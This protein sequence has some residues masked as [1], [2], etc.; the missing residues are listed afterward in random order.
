MAKKKKDDAA[1]D[2][3]GDDEMDWFDDEDDDVDESEEKSP[4]EPKETLPVAPPP[5]PPFKPAG[6]DEGTVSPLQSEDWSNRV[7]DAPADAKALSSAP[8]LVFSS[9]P[10]LPPM[11]APDDSE[12]AKAVDVD[13]TEDEP[14]AVEPRPPTEEAATEE[15]SA[16]EVAAAI[17]AA[18]PPSDAE[19]EVV[20]P[21]PEPAAV[22]EPQVVESGDDD[23]DEAEDADSVEEVYGD[24]LD[25]QTAQATP[26]VHSHDPAPLR[27]DPPPVRVG[28]AVQPAASPEPAFTPPSARPALERWTPPGDD[29]AWREVAM[30][31]VSEAAAAKGDARAHLLF[32]AAT[33][34]YTR[35]GD[36]DGAETLFRD[37]S[38]AG[39]NDLRL[40]RALTDIAMAADR[41]E[42]GLK[43]LSDAAAAQDG[44]AAAELFLEA[45]GVAMGHLGR[46]DDAAGLARQAV[47]AAPN[48]YAALSMLRDLSSQ[49]GDDAEKADVLRRLAE[50]SEGYVAADALLELGRALKQN[51]AEGSLQALRDAVKASPIHGSAWL[52]LERS[53]TER[54]AYGELAALYTT[55][56]QR[57]GQPDAG[58]WSLR[59]ARAHRDGGASE[60]AEIAFGHAVAAGYLFAEREL[61]AAHI[62]D[63]A[64]EALA[65]SLEAEAAAIE[66]ADAAFTWYRLALVREKHLDNASGALEAYKMVVRLD[67]N[68]TPAGDAAGRL[69]KAL[70]QTDD[71]MGFWQSRLDVATDDANRAAMMFRMAEIAEGEGDLAKAR[72]WYEQALDTGVP[73]IMA[74]TE[75]G[76]ARVL[77]ALGAWTELAQLYRNRASTTD[78]PVAKAEALFRAA[79]VG[80]HEPTDAELAVTD[81]RGVLAVSPA[82][83]GALGLVDVLLSAT[84]LWADLAEILK[85]AAGAT[86][87]SSA[88]A[89]LL[90]RAGRLFADSVSDSSRAQPCLE[91]SV[92]ADPTFLPAVW[93]LRQIAGAASENAQRELYVKQSEASEDADIA[94][95]CLFAASQLAGAAES[96]IHLQKLLDGR[97]DHPG[98]LAAMEIVCLVGGESAALAE[99]YAGSLVGPP[100]AAGARLTARIAELRAGTGQNDEALKALSDLI[101]MES[102]G[103]PLRGAARLAEGLGAWNEAAA[104]LE[105]LDNYED[106][107]HRSRILVRKLRNPGA[108]LPILKECLESPSSDLG[109]ALVASVVARLAQ[110]RDAMIRAHA[111]LATMAESPTLK[112]AYARWT[113]GMLAADNREDEALAYWQM[114]LALRPQSVVAFEGVERGMISIGNGDGLKQLYA[115]QRPSDLRGLAMALERAEEDEPAIEVLRTALEGD[116]PKLANL[117]ILEQALTRGEKWQEVYD[118]V[119]RRREIVVDEGLKAQIDAKRRW[120]L[121]EKL[122]ET[123]TA[124]E[125][126]QKLHEES[127]DDREVTEA[128]ARI[129]GARG[130]TDRAIQYLKELAET[131]SDKA[132][133][134]RYQRRVG[135]AYES[136]GDTASARQAYLDALDHV[137][138]DRAALDGLKRLAEGEEDWAGMV[139]VLQ[140]EAGI[141]DDDRRLELRREIAMITEDKIG[142]PAVAM[143]AWRAVLEEAQHD[144]EALEHLLGLS[145]SQGEWGVFIETG[146][147]LAAITAGPEQA[148]LFRRMGIVCQEQLD[149]DDAIRY[150][151][152]AVA[153][154]APDHEAAVQL[155]GMYRSR[156]DWSGAV[157]TLQIQ[158]KV[159]E[160]E[161]DRVAA[162]LK[163]AQ[164]EV[165]NRHDRDAAS[166]FFAQILDVDPKQI[167]AMR[168]MSNHLFETEKFEEALA[169]CK[170]L[171]PDV[172]TDQDMEDFDTRMEVSSF[173]FCFGEML[174]NTEQLDEALP[175]YER[176]L[177]LN[178][179]H[180][181][182]LEAIGPL[183][184]RD[185]QWKKAERVYRQLLQL[186]G[187]QG[188]RHAVAS[189]YTQLGLVERKLGSQDKAYKR[190]NK[191]LEMYP[192]HVGA[193]NGMALIL[194]DREDWSNLLN[195]YNNIIYH[196]TAHNDVIDAYM[197]KGRIL[198]DHMTRPD[199]AAQHYQRSLDFDSRQPVAYVRLAELAMRRDDYQEA[200][201]LAEAALALEDLNDLLDPVRP[202]LLL[203]KAAALKDGGK[204]DAAAKS[205]EEARGKAEKELDEALGSSPLDDL[206]TLRQ[207]IKDAI[208][209]PVR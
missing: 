88:K 150:L 187:G 135:D 107:L 131:A 142:D 179:T 182:T 152:Q 81:L 138:D 185:E 140:R 19:T 191:A 197:T 51:D 31:M 102:E 96:R 104:L 124:W 47:S 166:T 72:E 163:A 13:Q 79:T 112:G 161:A 170:R 6:A 158:G 89:S 82:H 206:D 127:P 33:I 181:A 22:E 132:E 61:Q 36:H 97:P 59:A 201:T 205:L 90:Y 129:A 177:E 149:R 17:E 136:N 162:L 43:H 195:I 101:A 137:P 54:G 175:R 68:A 128:V 192:N 117:L 186:S 85:E 62:K 176:A 119:A 86:E 26:L 100:T 83:S 23:A 109:A 70:G 64:W 49:I 78:S 156:A 35:V 203:C 159:A 180:L 144:T 73:A 57:E 48:D 169:V 165:G 208:P 7:S 141:A 160:A 18:G 66:G 84:E 202:L 75:D 16:D 94:H 38:S 123:D 63:S 115:E 113:A 164:I 14:T 58:W 133:S 204:A 190:F 42:D 154:D 3:F 126:Y 188:E 92:D 77:Y 148:V 108:S 45:A 27:R 71:L 171:E 12:L 98:A 153:G 167:D 30:A 10:T 145:E 118:V 56:A 155:E 2:F 194:E 40:R 37:A 196:A 111:A 28:V 95:W 99:L 146:N 134:A 80:K 173:F 116:G 69:M 55:E 207:V 34:Y 189:T 106:K 65:K 93:L 15:A 24:D 41:F 4:A 157:R 74:P 184:T 5:P 105:S 200:G 39:L 110:D 53:L 20:E 87:D 21:E 174:N 168:F 52:E 76:L 178:P 114:D 125:L 198:D 151:E 139:Q 143:D 147:S 1:A 46:A 121:A 44:D 183:Y 11:D 25:D 8:T 193:L 199:K 172:E 91:S 103:R 9:V 120:L 209:M 29:A 60:E 67:G 122:A 32:E 50:S 130:E